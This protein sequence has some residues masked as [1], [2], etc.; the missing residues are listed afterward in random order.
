MPGREGSKD[1]IRTYSGIRT[2]EESHRLNRDGAGWVK[3]LGPVRG[4]QLKPLTAP[5]SSLQEVGYPTQSIR[6]GWDLGL[7]CWGATSG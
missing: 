2:R 1:A 6:R 5:Y 3:T 4:Q 7:G